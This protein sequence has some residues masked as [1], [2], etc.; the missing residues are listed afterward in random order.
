M[1]VTSPTLVVAVKGDC[2]G[3]ANFYSGSLEALE[4]LEVVIVTNSLKGAPELVGATHVVYEAPDLLE[5][6]GVTWPPFYVLISP[7]PARVTAE[8]IAFT[9][10]QVAAEIAGRG[11]VTGP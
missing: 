8:G 3:C 6:L 9:P 11:N 4:G 5:A 10:E 1:T 2:D 7:A